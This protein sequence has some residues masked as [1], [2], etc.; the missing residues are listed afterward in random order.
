MSSPLDPNR[1]L[2][3]CM[4]T[5]KSADKAMAE[6]MNDADMKLGAAAMMLASASHT[7]HRHAAAPPREPAEPATGD[8]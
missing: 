1:I 8:T 7:V 2:Q 6:D 4:L 5:I 3:Q